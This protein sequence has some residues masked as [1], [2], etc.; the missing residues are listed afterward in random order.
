MN[1][2]ACKFA[3]GFFGALGWAHAGYAIAT[4]CGVV[5][6]PTFLGRTWGVGHMW[7]EAA[8][9]TAIAAALGYF[10]WVAA[11]QESLAEPVDE[12]SRTA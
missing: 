2:E 3:S 11:P 7:T 1:R 10:G 6:E 4:S 5:D 9:Y 8:V 12:L